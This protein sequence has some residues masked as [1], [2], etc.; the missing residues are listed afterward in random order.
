MPKFH[1]RNYPPPD[2]RRHPNCGDA[3]LATE[4]KNELYLTFKSYIENPTGE[5]LMLNIPDEPHPKPVLLESV[6][7]TAMI[8]RWMRG[9]YTEAITLILSDIEDQHDENAMQNVEDE[10]VAT[11]GEDMRSVFASLTDNI[12]HQPRPLC[13]TIHIDE[14]SYDNFLNHACAGCLTSAFCDHHGISDE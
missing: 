6:G 4:L 12:R 7:G 13:A 2:V 11:N 10:L 3:T 5:R 8:A 9:Q 14:H 1:I